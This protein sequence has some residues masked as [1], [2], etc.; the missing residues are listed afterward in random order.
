MCARSE[1]IVK[2]RVPRECVTLAGICSFSER[3][4]LDRYTRSLNSLN[5][6]NS[7]YT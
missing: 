1:L 5:S 3:F 6:L 7:L 4:R 2:Q